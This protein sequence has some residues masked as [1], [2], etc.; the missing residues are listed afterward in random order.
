MPDETEAGLVCSP[1]N[2]EFH[3]PGSVKITASCGHLVWISE[4]GLLATINDPK[5][6]TTCLPC[7]PG[8]AEYAGPV[9]GAMDE[10]ASLV[11]PDL[12]QQAIAKAQATFDRRDNLRRGP[13]PNGS[14]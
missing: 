10:L 7:M 12:A 1:A 13:G 8:D 14:H 3:T 11:G 5:M 6:T 4:S 2:S 9:P